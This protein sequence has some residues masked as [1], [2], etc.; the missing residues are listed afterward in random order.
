MTALATQAPVT[1]VDLGL[2]NIRSVVRSFQR[3]GVPV[4]R[5]A[6]PAVVSE[7]KCLVV[8]GQGAFRDGVA[9]LDTPLGES[10]RAALSSGRPYL[11]I[12]LGMQLLFEGSEECPGAPGLGHFK[13]QVRRFSGRSKVPHMGWNQIQVKAASSTEL[14]RTIVE[15]EDWFYFVHSFYCEP[16]DPS[17]VVA[18]T[19]YEGHFCSAVAGE[20][21]FACQFHPEKS[22][23][24]GQRL[25]SRFLEQ[26]CVSTAGD[27]LKGCA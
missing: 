24:A 18:T 8:P 12:C 19:D 15:A 22:Q 9:A 23:G 6:D 3:L 5:T 16:E 26:A 11:G 13:G 4:H 25:L 17:T 1:V 14:G 7:A 20:G 2:G 27:I 10:L 21:V